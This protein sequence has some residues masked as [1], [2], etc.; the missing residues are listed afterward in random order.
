[1][2]AGGAK[3][4]WLAALVW[5][6]GAVLM[7][8]TALADEV[9][10]VDG[11]RI[12]GSNIRVADGTLKIDTAFAKNLAIPMDQVAGVTT[13]TPVAV[14]LPTGER[15]I[16]PL[17]SHAGGV[18]VNGSNG[19]T[20]VSMS[21]VARV[22]DPQGPSPEQQAAEAARPKWSG[23]FEAGVDGRTG[24]TERVTVQGG[25][26]AT[27]S[28][29]DDRLNFYVRGRYENQNGKR[30]ANEVF[31]GAGYEYDLNTR[32]FVFAKFDLEYDEFEDLD[33]RATVLGGIGYFFI[34]EDDQ[35]LKGRVGLGY[36]H[37]SFG[38]GETTNEG[39]LSLGY[40]YWTQINS[41]TRFTHAGTFIPALG[42]LTDYTATLDTGLEFALSDDKAW[43]L[44][45]GM[46]N[47]YDP[48]PAPGVGKLDTSYFAN[49]A[50]DW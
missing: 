18:S 48:K 5:L 35:E 14:D 24:N 43:K 47:E 36:R 13:D 50:F 26:S 34:R 28:T 3:R 20:S 39:V 40:D 31:G 1:M 44:R 16:G 29:P 38:S 32:T 2:P 30:S 9:T 6:S 7:P 37:E 42:D 49:I 12:V 33:L 41:R 22:W 8:P 27:R 17:S 15:Y 23:R 10:L 21:D 4:W 25:A 46:R 45:L 11:S 19:T